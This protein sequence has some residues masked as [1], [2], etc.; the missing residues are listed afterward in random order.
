MTF[1]SEDGPWG[2][3]V[4]EGEPGRQAPCAAQR[5]RPQPRPACPATT[6]PSAPAPAPPGGTLPTSAAPPKRVRTESV[7]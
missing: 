5:E 1:C 2:R 6:A 7:S 3:H 4:H